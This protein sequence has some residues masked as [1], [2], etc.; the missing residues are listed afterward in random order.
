MADKL[1]VD[2]VAGNA[3]TAITEVEL[4]KKSLVE[5]SATAKALPGLE[6]LDKQIAG[7]QTRAGSAQKTF[8]GLFKFDAERE[9]LDR[10]SQSSIR[11]SKETAIVQKRLA[12]I[13]AVNTAGRSESFIK[14]LAEDA[15]DAEKTLIRLE[16]RAALLKRVESTGAGPGI[17]ARPLQGFGGLFRA[18]GLTQA[19]ITE[20]EGNVAL[21]ALSKL[22]VGASAIAVASIAVVGAAFVAV[23]EKIK[24]EADARLAI[25]ERAAAQINRQIISQREVLANHEREKQ[26]L[27][28]I[29]RFTREIAD[30]ESDRDTAGA[31][32]LADKVEQQ[33]VA[34]ELEIDRVKKAIEADER[35]AELEKKRQTTG[36][37]ATL[38]GATPF[39]ESNK[40]QAEGEAKA[41]LERDKA[42][43]AF[44]QGLAGQGTTDKAAAL[45]LLQDI[46]AKQDKDFAGRFAEFQREQERNRQFEILSFRTI[47]DKIKV[48]VPELQKGLSGVLSSQLLKPEDRERLIADFR[49]AILTQINEGRRHVEEFGK[50]TDELFARLFAKKGSSNPF[51]AVYTEAQNAI[52]QTRLST[53]GL[54]ADLVAQAD[55]LVRNN[56]ANALFSARLDNALQVSDLRAAAA[57]FRKQ[58]V[59]TADDFDNAFKKFSDKAANERTQFAKVT[60]EGGGFAGFTQFRANPFLSFDRDSSLGGTVSRD[61]RDTLFTAFDRLGSGGTIRRERSFAELTD[62]E[63]R[64]VVRQFSQVSPDQLSAQQRLDRQLSIIQASSPANDQQRAEADRKIIALTQGLNPADLTESQRNDAAAARE[65]EAQRLTNAEADAAKQRADALTVQKSIDANIKA[66]LDTAKSDGLQGVIR[67]INEATDKASDSLG[68]RRR[69]NDLDAKDLMTP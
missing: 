22:G 42:R 38:L 14:I 2:L 45:K 67:I 69:A 44:L 66:L 15:A 65:R 5:T 28:A 48:T 25:E 47:L 35:L 63:K 21:Q 68:K 49:A 52:E 16:A 51:V 8:Q 20:A 56:N 64:A 46:T 40:R 19:G 43:L 7:L 60:G 36:T 27:E 62:N 61:I 23:T 6:S 34:R 1:Q 18:S 54:T 59:P 24:H 37:V 29:A 41:V 33:N 4:F 39:T 58:L 12:D 10:L 53:A 57:D 50:S 11:L 26:N 3:K 32:A 9:S 13:A 17:G 30:L 31:K 55:Q